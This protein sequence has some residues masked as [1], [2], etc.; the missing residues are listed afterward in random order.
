MKQFI[1]DDESMAVLRTIYCINK[2]QKIHPDISDNM[3]DIKELINWLIEQNFLLKQ[4]NEK[5]KNFLNLLADEGEK[6]II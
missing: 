2:I 4:E 1:Q 5:Q 3:E 6:I